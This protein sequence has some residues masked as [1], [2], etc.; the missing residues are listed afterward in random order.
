MFGVM[1]VTCP[2]TKEASRVRTSQPASQP[3]RRHQSGQGP[4]GP[5]RREA[6]QLKHSGR[7]AMCVPGVGLFPFVF[8]GWRGP[9][10]F[11]GLVWP[12]SFW[13]WLVPL[14][15]LGLAWPPFERWFLF[16]TNLLG[17]YSSFRGPFRILPAGQEVP[18]ANFRGT[19]VSLFASANLPRGMVYKFCFC[20]HWRRNNVI[21]S[22]VVF[23]SLC[24]LGLHWATH[25][26]WPLACKHGATLPRS[27]REASANLPR[28]T[29]AVLA[30][31]A[32]CWHLLF[33]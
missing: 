28:S 12:L 23:R 25:A 15:F 4:H 29:P 31:L 7:F 33:E 5:T 27:F 22:E 16:P 26:T 14:R 9:L 10:W 17:H 24:R 30:F 32:C 8:W 18:S 20:E 21:L 19:G 6:P 3:L 2:C 1:A 13:G 11:V